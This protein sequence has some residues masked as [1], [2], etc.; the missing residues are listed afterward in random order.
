MNGDFRTTKLWTGSFLLLVPLLILC[1][2][3]VDVPVGLFVKHHLYANV[4]W[5]R[6]TTDLPDLLLLVVVLVTFAALSTY[7]V[8]TKKGI[9]DAL[10][11]WARLITWTAPASYLAKSVLKFI[12]GRVNTRNWTHNPDLYSFHWLSGGDGF[13]GFPSGHMVVMVT[14]FAALCRFFPRCRALSIV[15]LSLL[16]LALIATNYHFVSDVIAGAYVGIAVEALLFRMLH[17]ERGRLQFPA[18]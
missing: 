2:L 12:F 11:D 8:R 14:L 15:T 3:Y 6:L 1:V 4:K 18:I 7:L 10:T 16:G 9:Y 5:S 13:E 17:G